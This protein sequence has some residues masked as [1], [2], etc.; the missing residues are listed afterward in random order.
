MRHTI[1][2]NARSGFEMTDNL[3]LYLSFCD[4]D[5]VAPYVDQ[6]ISNQ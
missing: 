6:N 1:M 5:M 3:S 4:L 2:G